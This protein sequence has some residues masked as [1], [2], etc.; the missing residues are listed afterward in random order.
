MSRYCTCRCWTRPQSPSRALEECVREQKKLWGIF[1]RSAPKWARPKTAQVDCC[2]HAAPGY[3][4]SGLCQEVVWPPASVRSALW[5]KAVGPGFSGP[6]S[7]RHHW[8]VGYRPSSADRLPQLPHK[9][10]RFADLSEWRCSHKVLYFGW[11]CWACK[12]VNRSSFQILVFYPAHH[13]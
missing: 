9:T 10:L 5:Q 12:R 6:G 1:V 11:R 4:A 7:W 3:R 8:R 13:S 2:A